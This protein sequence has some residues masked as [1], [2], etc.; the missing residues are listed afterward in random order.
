MIYK[1]VVSDG[2]EW[3]GGVNFEDWDVFH[4]FDGTSRAEHWEPVRVERF[5]AIEGR[6]NRPSDFPWLASSTLV[7]RRRAVDALRSMLEPGAEILPLATDDG[8]ELF[9]LNITRVLDD[10]LDEE[11][12]TL[13]RFP[14]SQRIILIEA[15]AFREHVVCDVDFFQLRQPQVLYVG[16]R[17]VDRVHAAGLVGLS[18]VPAWSPERGPI[19]RS[20]PLFD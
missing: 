10:A 4:S 6:D 1:P 5:A 11:R 13:L 9:V 12:S 8:V 18:F 17:F 15:A 14:D 7:L 16:D 3:V 19:L 20:L 2:F